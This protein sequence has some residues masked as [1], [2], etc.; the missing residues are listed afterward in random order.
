M[1]NKD[2]KKNPLKCS[3][4]TYTGAD[5][6][7]LQYHIL[8]FHKYHIHKCKKCPYSAILKR[9]L[10]IHMKT[11]H[12][13]IKNYVYCAN[14]PFRVSKKF[15]LIHHMQF[16]FI[17]APNKCKYCTFTSKH[18]GVVIKHE[19]IHGKSNVNLYK[20][21]K[22]AYFTRIKHHFNRHSMQH[23]PS[24]SIA[25]LK[26]YCYT[27]KYSTIH[28]YSLARHVQS[29]LKRLA[30]N[31]IK[32]EKPVHKTKFKCEHCN[33]KTSISEHMK[34]HAAI[35][36]KPL[37][38][39]SIKCLTCSYSTSR[40]DALNH[41]MMVHKNDGKVLAPVEQRK[42]IHACTTCNY[43]TNK[44][45]GLERH[46]VIHMTMDEIKWFECTE[47]PFKAKRKYHL[48]AHRQGHNTTEGIKCLYCSFYS[49]TH[50]KFLRHLKLHY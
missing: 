49:G 12:S 31:E 4:C 5:I 42:L 40:K 43:T 27:C 6:K 2:L 23:E 32:K 48:K 10:A 16:H 34:R 50:G 15:Q 8:E 29:C 41:H 21:E 47:C 37:R 44:K 11:A 14:C 38:N 13:H 25:D 39:K 19:W 26:Y 9:N 24:E 3:I 46:I 20:C 45:S 18:K 7:K 35:H 1:E 33:Y 17:N 28:K 36:L 30:K 22:C